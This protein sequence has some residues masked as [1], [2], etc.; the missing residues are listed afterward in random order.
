MDNIWIVTEKYTG[1]FC[2][3][4][5]D[6]RQAQSKCG[7]DNEHYELVHWDTKRQVEIK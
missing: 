3:A 1:N 7:K 6:K 2:G 4:F 5:T